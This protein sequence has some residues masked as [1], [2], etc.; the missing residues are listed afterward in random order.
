MVSSGARANEAVEAPTGRAPRKRSRLSPDD[1]REHLVRTAI[2]L[3]AE[4]G[5]EATSILRVTKTAGV[6]NGIFYHYFSN[7]KELEDAV[8]AVVLSDL[9][10]ELAKV[11]AAERYAD[12]IA[13]GAVGMMRAVAADRELGAIMAQF[14]EQHSAALK[15]LPL[16]IADDVD[17]GIESGEFVI[18]MP[19]H[20]VVGLLI[21]TLGV[22]ARE[23]LAEARADDIGEF[24]AATHL[25]M[26][27]VPRRQAAAVATRTRQLS[28]FLAE[29]ETKSRR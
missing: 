2:A 15:H 20:L 28:R 21:A 3:F 7:K 27:G 14:F 6:S 25:R 1:R 16:Q 18:D 8:G 26:L 17:G 9:V 23:V 22:G 13:I 19:R 11:Q 4:D 24:V 5:V 29:G 12:R 10:A